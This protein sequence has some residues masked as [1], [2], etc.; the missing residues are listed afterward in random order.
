MKTHSLGTVLPTKKSLE[1]NDRYFNDLRAEQNKIANSTDILKDAEKIEVGGEIRY[2]IGNKYA[3]IGRNKKVMWF[4]VR[5]DGDYS[6]K[7]P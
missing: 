5:K 4:E 3:I 6:I 1:I 2:Y 7:S